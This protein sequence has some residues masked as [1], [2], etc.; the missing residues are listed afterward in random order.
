MWGNLSRN[1]L[2]CPFRCGI[3]ENALQH[4]RRPLFSKS[5]TDTKSHIYTHEQVASHK[6]CIS[7]HHIELR[8]YQLEC[9]EYSLQ[10]MRDGVT[11]QA[12]SLPVGSGKTV[13]FSHL[14]PRVPQPREG[15]HQ[16]L[17]LAHRTEL[18]QQAAQKI[19]TAN[20]GLHVSIEQGKDFASEESDVIVASVPTLGRV[21]VVFRMQHCRTERRQHWSLHWEKEIGIG[22]RFIFQISLSI[23]GNVFVHWFWNST[24]SP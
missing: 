24:I 14:I 7:Q 20:P 3:R 4:S 19:S 13:I 11:R 6:R 10:L 23:S 18:L 5:T 22:M 17:V 9:I 8:P 12:V 1:T 21:Q 15:A 16:T 2:S